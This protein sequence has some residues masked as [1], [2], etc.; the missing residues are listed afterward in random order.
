[1]KCSVCEEKLTAFSNTMLL[2]AWM[3]L[4]Q[5]RKAVLGDEKWRGE[6]RLETQL[7]RMQPGNTVIEL[8]KILSSFS[9]C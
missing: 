6:T 1:M 5:W 4:Q 8:P 7:G 2:G 9:A 3:C